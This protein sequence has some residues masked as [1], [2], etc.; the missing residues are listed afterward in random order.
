MKKSRHEKIIELIE[1]REIETQ[2]EL[3]S[4]LEK[5]GYPVTQA[6]ISRDIKELHLMKMSS[7]NGKQHYRLLP[8]LKTDSL[9]KYN[10]V[11]KEGLLRMDS[12]ENILV[13]HTMAGMANAVAAAL[14]QSKLPHIMGT[15]AGD[16][17][18]MCVLKHKEDVEYAMA[19]LESRISR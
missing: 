3:V 8:E 5:E 11:L 14:D 10:R 1:T 19:D 17:T 15:L 6:T 18:V 12:A 16:D 2:E 4:A 13:L 7:A 9:D